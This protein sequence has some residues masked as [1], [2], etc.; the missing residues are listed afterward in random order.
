M[1]TTIEKM[2]Q[3]LIICDDSVEIL[4]QLLDNETIDLSKLIY[5]IFNDIFEI[6]NE[7]K[8]E[9]MA[10][11]IS[12]ICVKEQNLIYIADQ[13][14]LLNGE[15]DE[16]QLKRKKF[17]KKIFFQINN[18]RK[19]INN[20]NLDIQFMCDCIDLAASIVS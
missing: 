1:E 16:L 9:C 3:K 14:R 6:T 15:N 5:L 8:I 7:T 2:V 4:K 17:L 18:Q 10:Q 12:E 20:A 13:I 19:K 11:V